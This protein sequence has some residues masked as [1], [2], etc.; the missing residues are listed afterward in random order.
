MEM[1][2]G[3]S[4]DRGDVV[5]VAVG[6]A[7]PLRGSGEAFGSGQKVFQNLNLDFLWFGQVLIIGQEDMGAGY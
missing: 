1:S 7:D 6:K 2:W 3:D 5:E 4:L